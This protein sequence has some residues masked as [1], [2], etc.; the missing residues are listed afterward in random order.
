MY[1]AVGL[2]T[3]FT[4]HILWAGVV[5]FVLLIQPVRNVR[6]Y[7]CKFLDMINF[8][9]R[10]PFINNKNETAG[11][12][13]DV[14]VRKFIACFAFTLAV[15]NYVAWYTQY[16]RKRPQQFEDLAMEVKWKAQKWRSERDLYMDLCIG[17]VYLGVDYICKLTRNVQQEMM[18]TNKLKVE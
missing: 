7:T 1:S 12:A 8:R 14:S 4:Y 13:S 3:S 11:I 6:L 18:L 5:A 16:V 9:V 2:W 10:T 17:I 15:I